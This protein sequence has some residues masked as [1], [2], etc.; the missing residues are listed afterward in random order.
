MSRE[1]ENQLDNLIVQALREFPLEPA[2]A[3]LKGNIMDQLRVPMPGRRFRISWVD[4]AFSGILALMVG[5]AIEL[6]QDIIRSPYWSTRFQ[7]SLLHFWQDIKYFLL[8]NQ[9]SVVTVTLSAGILLSLLA[10]LASVYWRYAVASNR[11]ASY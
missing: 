11:M 10:I 4:L 8:H 5:S 6:V 3:Q 7:V 1:R 9:S 2:P